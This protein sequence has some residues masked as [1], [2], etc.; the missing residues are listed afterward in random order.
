MKNGLSAPVHQRDSDIL[1][2]VW[3]IGVFGVHSPH[4]LPFCPQ[5]FLRVSRLPSLAVQTEGVSVS[6]GAVI[7]VS[8][9]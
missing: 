4:G 2:W 3:S 5:P 6:S 7:R 8:D 1:G 9:T